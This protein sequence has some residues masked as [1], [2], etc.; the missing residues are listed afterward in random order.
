VSQFIA[1]TRSSQE[2]TAQLHDFALGNLS[3]CGSITIDK[4]AAG[5]GSTAFDFTR[6]GTGFT[7]PFTL[8]DA[9]T[10]NTTN[11]LTP[12]TYTVT[13]AVEAAGTSPVCRATPASR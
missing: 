13:E 4:V 10:P 6:T 7:T 5:G 1:E 11:N 8:T 3:T 12:G 2:T 9:Q